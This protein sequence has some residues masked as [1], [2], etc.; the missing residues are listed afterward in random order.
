MVF[1]Y[2]KKVLH[3]EDKSFP[4]LVKESKTLKVNQLHYLVEVKKIKSSW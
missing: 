4:A 1:I 2:L 3:V